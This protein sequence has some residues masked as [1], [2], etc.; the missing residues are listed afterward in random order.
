MKRFSR[1]EVAKAGSVLIQNNPTIRDYHHAM[2]VLNYWRSQHGYPINTFQ[3]TLRDKLKKIDK[4]ALVAQRLKRT[5]SIVAKLDRFP[6]MNLSRMQDIAGLRAVVAD[7]D[8]VYQLVDTYVESKRF[9]HKLSRQKDYIKEPKESGYRGVHLVYKY[10]N[11]KAREFENL[12]VEIQ[13]R[14]KLQHTWATAVETMGTFLNQPLKASQGSDEWLE[15][16]SLTGDAFARLES[17]PSV[18]RYSQYK[19]ST[20]Y[21]ETTREAERLKVEDQ[22][23]AFTVAAHAISKDDQLG[24][25]H[26]IILDVVRKRVTIESY[27]RKRLEEANLRYTDLEKKI[28][29]G[30]ELQAVLVSAGPIDDLKRAYPNYFLDTQIFLKVLNSIKI[31]SKGQYVQLPLPLW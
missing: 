12:S 7:T 13:I 10:Q 4:N 31:K 5:P 16:F 1:K 29:N 11:L 23:K 6:K 28:A 27:G 15:F 25:Y 8:K 24:H 2:E 17:C 18:P 3:A 9:K 21:I 20:I 22:L 14:T 30:R 19:N 26:L